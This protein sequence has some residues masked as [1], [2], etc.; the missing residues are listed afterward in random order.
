M[1]PDLDEG[2]GQERNTCTLKDNIDEAW[3]LFYSFKSVKVVELNVASFALLNFT[4]AWVTISLCRYYFDYKSNVM[5][6][7]NVQHISLLS[8]QL[9]DFQVIS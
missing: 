2:L 1:L 7:W 8:A 5:C 9:V 6:V 4:I 3:V